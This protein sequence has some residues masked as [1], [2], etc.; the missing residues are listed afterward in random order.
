MK[1]NLVLFFCVFLLHTQTYSQGGLGVLGAY[2]T[3]NDLVNKIDQT[4]KVSTGNI[5][6]MSDGMFSKLNNQLS[7]A[8]QNLKIILGQELNKSIDNL[9]TKEKIALVELEKLRLTVESY[10][11]TAFDLKDATILDIQTIVGNIIPWTK[12]DFMVQ[13]IDGILQM[14]NE[15][16]YKLKFT[17]I[18][19]G[20][21][22]EK[23]LAS[24][25]K[26]SING[27]KLKNFI[28]NKIG[29]YTSY[30]MI[31]PNEINTQLNSDKKIN[32]IKIE[33]EV[34][35]NRKKTFNWIVKTHNI[36]FTIDIYPNYAG[37]YKVKYVSSSKIWVS[38]IKDFKTSY[39][40]P[41]HD[42]HTK[43]HDDI[44]KFLWTTHYDLPENKRFVNPRFFG[45]K[46]NGKAFMNIGE[47]STE[48]DGKTIKIW[49]ENWGPP[50][51]VFFGGDIEKQ[52]IK[53]NP[54]TV[55]DEKDF[56]YGKYIYFDLPA[57]ANFWIVEGVTITGKKFQITNK[58]SFL[59][60]AEF[61]DII[62]LGDDKKRI[63]YKIN[64]P[65]FFY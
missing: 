32:K 17:G 61:S 39:T 29:N 33:V 1:R 15:D 18:G 27:K 46:G 45:A 38:D 16:E 9:G 36:S 51:I 14:K 10:K 62:N 56:Y 64:S 11:K 60:L 23:F 63:M 21:N 53:A 35:T 55:I 22:S 8:E 40:I 2:L 41:D 37:K 3:G 47:V 28:E 42:Q 50:C 25:T 54:E 4:L 24:I 13:K 44:Q 6:L 58:D 7:V 19:F 49:G 31:N 48:S 20:A 34:E 12:T 59:P 5:D 65:D 57:E 26:V 30:L 43:R 52:E